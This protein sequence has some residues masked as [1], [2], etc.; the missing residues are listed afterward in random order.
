[1]NEWKKRFEMIKERHKKTFETALKQG[2]MD[3]QMIQLCQYISKT[4]NYYTSSC[5]SGRIILLEKKGKRKIDTFFHRKWHREINIAE[6]LEGI[7]E[8][9]EGELWLRLDPFILHIGCPSIKEAQKILTAM[10]KAGVKRGGITVAEKGKFLI[11]LQGTHIFSCIVKKNGKQLIQKKYLEYILPRLNTMLA[12]NY[13]RL[14]KLETE[15][16][17]TLE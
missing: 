2:K 3:E 17:K 10:K 14:E 16:K 1:M 12:E 15:F 11:E 4:K 7:K 8:N 9:K 13:Q 6:L 5:C